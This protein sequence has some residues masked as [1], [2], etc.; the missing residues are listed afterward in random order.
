MGTLLKGQTPPDR[1]AADKVAAEKATAEVASWSWHREYPDMAGF[2]A[3]HQT[4]DCLATLI[5]QG[6]PRSVLAAVKV[7]GEARRIANAAK[8]AEAAA[9][10]VPEVPAATDSKAAARAFLAAA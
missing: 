9:K 4:V 10:A 2:M 3:G 5:D 6:A 7:A 8:R 1:H